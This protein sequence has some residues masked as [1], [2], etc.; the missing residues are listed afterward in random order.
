MRRFAGSMLVLLLALPAMPGQARAQDENEPPSPKKRYDMLLK[1]F[2]SQQRE[3]ATTINK[4]QGDERQKLIQ[5][6]LALGK[7]Y[8][9]KFYKLAEDAPKDPVA[10]DALFWVIQF[11]NGTAVHAKASE[12]LLADYPDH[13]A[14][15]RLCQLLGNSRDPKVVDT[16][17]QILEKS[18]KPRVKAAAAL[19][20]GKRLAAQT[21]TLGDKLAEA[22]KVAARADKYLVLAIDLYGKDT[23]AASEAERELKSLRTLRVGKEAPEISAA[24]LDAKDFKLSDY[25]GKVVMLDFWGNW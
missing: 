8:A 16:L 11:G 10:A 13:P 23:P 21:D 1:D 14:I 7:D 17:Q 3:L 6:Y 24:D 22:D 2:S 20:L 12:R 15:E 4:V 25:R 5:K 19:G 9:E 18:S